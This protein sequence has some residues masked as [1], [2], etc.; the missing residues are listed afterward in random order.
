M[1]GEDLCSIGPI[2]VLQDLTVM[3]ALG[4]QSVERNGHHYFP[5]LSMFSKRIQQHV[6]AAHND[7]Y[8]TTGS[9][10]PALDIRDGQIEIGSLN[11][12]PF[13]VGFVVD[14][15]QFSPVHDFQPKL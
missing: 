5:G 11:K 8:R 3:A 13:G 7:V 14:V 6:L 9:G 12:S 2:S 15:E 1:S 10:W 4:I